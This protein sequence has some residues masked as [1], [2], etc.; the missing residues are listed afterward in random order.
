[1]YELLELLGSALELLDLRLHLV[2]LNDLPEAL[3]VLLAVEQGQRETDVAESARTTYS[4][5]VVFEVRLSMLL[6]D[7][8]IDDQFDLTHIKTSSQQIGRDD[9]R[10]FASAEL[11]NVLVSLLSSHITKYDECAVA[12]VI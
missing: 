5:D 10:N 11:V 9:H 7:V 1:M 12:L 6:R 2:V 4:V 8:E 3:L